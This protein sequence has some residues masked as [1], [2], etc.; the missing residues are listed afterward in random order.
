MRMAKVGRP[1]EYDEFVHPQRAH[2]LCLMGATDEDLARIFEVAESTIN[3]WK[4]KYPEFLESIKEAK[5][6]ADANVANSLYRQAIGYRQTVEKPM[7]VS[8]GREG[9]HVEIV[10][11]EETVNPVTTAGIFWLKNR[12]RK[13]W[14]DRQDVSISDPNGDPIQIGITFKHAKEGNK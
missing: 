12:Q 10:T 8:D 2:D 7:A 11:Y 6:I 5:D 4:K 14:T 9:S 3:T 1:S 13:H